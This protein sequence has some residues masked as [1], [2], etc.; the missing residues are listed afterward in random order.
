MHRATRNGAALLVAAL[1]ALAVG[2][3]GRAR[4]PN[5]PSRPL[6]AHAGRAAELFSDTIEPSAVGL[7]FDRGYQ[8]RT[9]PLFRERTQ[10]SD[11]VLRVKVQ[12]V[13]TRRDGTDATYV[14]GLSTVEVLGGRHPPPSPFKVTIR[15]ESESHGIMRSFESRLVNHEFIA[16]VREFVQP[17]GDTEIHFHLAPDTKAVKIAVNDALVA[18]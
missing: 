17:D 11:A 14:L 12:N 16:F 7:D 13:T 5:A 8:P 6:S 2:A 1:A 18:R 15:K 9:D 4:D 3:C 10:V